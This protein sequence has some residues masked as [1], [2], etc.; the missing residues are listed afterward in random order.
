MRSRPGPYGSNHAATPATCGKVRDNQRVKNVI[1]PGGVRYPVTPDVERFLCSMDHAALQSLVLEMAGYSPEAMRSLQLRATPE[2]EPTASELLAAVDAALAGVDLDYHDPLYEDVDDGVQGVE[3]SVDE[4]ERHLDGGAHPVVRRVLQHLLTR[5]GDLARDADNADALLEVA[6]RASALFGRAAEGHPDPVTLARWVVD[7]RVEYGGWPSLALD[8]VAHAFDEPA[9]DAYRA[10]VATLGGAGPAA[11]PYRSEIDRMLLELAD[12]DGDVDRAVALL[13]EGEH[14]YYREILRRLRDAGRPADVLAW[15]DRAVT[16]GCVDVAWRAGPTIVPVE[17]AVDAYLDGG[18]PDAALAIARTLFDRDLSVDALRLL[19]HVAERCGR[20]D[21]QRTWAFDQATQRAHSSGGAHLV[22]LHL[23]DGNVTHAW[24]A[25]D[26]FGAGH[27]W[28]ELV[29][30]SEDGFPL[31]AARLC[32]AQ[33]L[34]S[35]TTPDSKRYPAIVD[36]L[37]KARALYDTAGHR[38]EADA[39]ILRLREVYRRR[40]ALM[41]AMNRA[42]LPASDT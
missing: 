40:P 38:A 33:V 2:D 19:S 9:W 14:P 34:E 18:R 16:Q 26:A 21:E 11:D 6:E 36:L 39:E 22:R 35:L 10:S 17:D 5:L 41:S 3:E 27:A 23:A 32:L 20:G 24:E 37:V 1:G 29:D 7:F 8:A 30:A 15:L 4:L 28:R 12:H 13:S 25:A 42:G 31:R